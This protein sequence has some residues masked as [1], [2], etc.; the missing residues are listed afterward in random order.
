MSNKYFD[1]IKK[2]PLERTLNDRILCDQYEHIRDYE[3]V[4]V[5]I[6]IKND[7]AEIKE[8]YIPMVDGVVD[9]LNSLSQLNHISRR[10]FLIL[11]NQLDIV[12]MLEAVALKRKI[13]TEVIDYTPVIMSVDQLELIQN[14]CEQFADLTYTS[15]QQYG[16]MFERHKITCTDYW[17]MWNAFSKEQ[18]PF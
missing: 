9:A 15:Q 10:S 14:Y 11:M 3:V 16:Q 4:C 1:A 7:L 18:T 5:H 2:H 12:S 6:L 17:L 13:E 8:W